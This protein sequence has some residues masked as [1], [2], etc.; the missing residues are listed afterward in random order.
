[1][2]PESSA[3]EGRSTYFFK[4]IFK[5]QQQ[6]LLAF[7]ITRGNVKLF[8]YCVWIRL[9]I[10]KI[11]FYNVAFSPIEWSTTMF[12][13][14]NWLFYRCWLDDFRAQCSVQVIG[15]IERLALIHCNSRL[16]PWCPGSVLIM[17]YLCVKPIKPMLAGVFFLWLLPVVW[18]VGN[19]GFHFV[20]LCVEIWPHV[21]LSL[22]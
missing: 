13:L 4:I 12:L 7:R 6:R 16:C 21:V 20:E 2:I 22:V 15:Y 17:R 1:M 9:R 19:G 11:I 3:C 18:K 14:G 8:L 5:P 10:L